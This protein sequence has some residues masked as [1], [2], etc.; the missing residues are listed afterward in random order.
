[1]VIKTNV[2]HAAVT[3]YTKTIVFSATID[4]FTWANFEDLAWKITDTR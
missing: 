2:I 3:Y 1:M 4:L